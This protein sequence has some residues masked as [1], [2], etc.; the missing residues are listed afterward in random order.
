MTD[1][2][3]GKTQINVISEGSI[4][5]IGE[6]FEKFDA[7]NVF[8]VADE[9]AYKFSGAEKALSSLLQEYK[10]TWF[11]DFELNPKIEDVE[12]GVALLRGNPPDLVIGLG[13]GS[14]LDMAKLIAG[15]GAGTAQPAE[16]V[17]GTVP[18]EHQIPPVIA[19]PTTSGT[20]SEATHFAVVYIKGEKFSFA[21]SQLLPDVALIDPQLTWSLPPRTTASCGLDALCQCVESV[22]AV[23]ATDES[24]KFASEGFALAFR[25]LEKAVLNPDAESRLAMAK[26]AHL[27]GKAINISKTTAPHAL[28]Y[29]IT[30]RYGVP[31]GMAVA[32]TLGAFLEY[33]SEMTTYDCIDTRGLEHV[34]KRID[35]IISLMD[36]NSPVQAANRVRSLLRAI[37]CPVCLKDAGIPKNDLLAISESVNTE[38]LSNNPRQIDIQ[39]LQQ[40]LDSV[41]E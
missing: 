3:T 1:T 40:L 32:L 8:F 7:R 36:C 12:R 26:A 18:M 28:S 38:R 37:N 29:G 25:H 15:C 21:H 30:S 20:G 13:G 16:Y 4:R 27:S 34:Q 41:F 14:A 6:F 10:V 22:W 17:T 2:I 33:N 31:H 9:P 5:Q 24:I 11:S 35:H 19:V 23:G 39:G